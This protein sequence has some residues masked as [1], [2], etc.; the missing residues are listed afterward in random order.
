ML[1]NRAVAL[2]LTLLLSPAVL[3]LGLGALKTSSALNQR[4]DGRIDILGAT[5][6]DVDTL[7]ARLADTQQFD[8]AGIQ[9]DAI[10][11]DLKFE[12]VS[13]ESGKDYIRITSREPIREPFLNFLLELNWANGRVVR[14][15]TVLLDPPLYDANRR[16]AAPSRAPA[17][18]RP[19]AAPT[20]R[21]PPALATDPT[22]AAQ[23]A[24]RPSAYTPGG[25]IGVEANDTLWSLATQH[26]PDSSV[27]VHQMMIA[28]LRANPEAFVNGNINLLKRGAVLRVP[29]ADEVNQVSRSVALEEIRKQHQLWED[30]RH[31][32]S[33][34]ATAQ[35]LGPG[36]ESAPAPKAPAAATA[37]SDGRL[38]LAA[39]G[40]SEGKSTDGKAAAPGGTAGKGTGPEAAG[41]EDIDARARENV[42]LKNKLSEADKII[43]LLQRQVEIKDQELATLQAR[44][45]K[46]GLG[47]G[48]TAA[49]PET[50]AAPPATA[51]APAP[52]PAPPVAEK[53]AA[54]E[55]PKPA[56]PT[57]AATPTPEAPKPE[58]EKP[59]EPAQ[60]STPAEP[61]APAKPVAPPTPATPAAKPAP[62]PA[63]PGFAES[64]FPA[65][66]VH[67]VPGGA[68]TLLAVVG[69]VLALVV[70]A[71]VKKFGGRAGEKPM[72]APKRA[73]ATAAAGAAA[74]AALAEPDHTVEPITETR[75]PGR[76]VDEPPTTP[77]GT[78]ERTLEATADQLRAE[79][80]EDP[81]EEV[82]VYLAYERFD[83]A[84]ELVK[85]V[86]AQQPNEHKFKLRLL[87]I[88]YSANNKRAYEESARELLNAVGDK[89]PLWENAVAMWTE[90]SPDRPLFTGGGVDETPEAA[91]KTFVDITGD[92]LPGGET[93]TM[94][95]GR[96]H[97]LEST[98]VGLG[99]EASVPG[100]DFDLSETG[101]GP[102]L[103]MLDL[104]AADTGAAGGDIFDPTLGASEPGE[105]LDLTAG[106]ADTLDL[107]S[108]PTP[109]PAA[110]GDMF[111]ISGESLSAADL[112]ALEPPPVDLL[113]VTSTGNLRLEGADDLLSLT[114]PGLTEHTTPQPGH[115]QAEAFDLGPASR[116]AVDF[117]I[118][119]TVNPPPRPE[120]V[121]AAPEAD[122]DDVLDFDIEGLGFD[123]A[124]ADAEPAIGETSPL[125]TSGLDLSLEDD[126]G[127]LDISGGLGSDLDL[128]LDA[129]ESPDLDLTAEA[130]PDLD[131]S[132]QNPEIDDF[133]LEVDDPNAPSSNES[134]IEFDLALQD[135]TDFDS[136][137]VDDTL[138]LP[139]S[140]SAFGKLTMG[141]NVEES[142][143]D[144]TRSMEESMA[145]LDLEEDAKDPAFDLDMAPLDANAENALDFDIDDAHLET[146]GLDAEDID[147][148]ATQS[149]IDRTVVLPRDDAFDLQDDAD[150]VD[151]KLNLAK[152]YLELGDNE[153]ARSILDE[154]VRDGSD[155][156]RA[157]AQKLLEQAG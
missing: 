150:E 43:D 129:G 11:L 93:M 30:Y 95:P 75:A 62:K 139:K 124:P 127:V 84:E 143:E 130:G 115:S 47:A 103:D 79:P 119:D 26:R 107:D 87:E 66:L 152:A 82:N 37:P 3:A 114:A 86:I 111:D 109:E 106:A 13:P 14:E 24:S 140:S 71:L 27:T 68:M 42:E 38:E 88:Y 31:G 21:M 65:Q 48:D 126:D 6:E 134:D 97:V 77:T 132:L 101:A 145:A 19:A 137:R 4:F 67:A 35:P 32:A 122:I 59:V 156:Q 89:D 90:M 112:T 133:E 85:K 7:N 157:E 50:P 99:E 135:T 28:L 51:E 142:L 116:S 105:I 18:S 155:A 148:N 64:L 91:S 102:E 72:P 78:F 104:T 34:R 153:G 2:A 33:Q 123:A 118:S 16:A 25:S 10:L 9:R 36:A 146:L 73:A 149:H 53:P 63:A 58:A 128:E 8:R 69:G 56:E 147:F 110:S 12:I 39:P 61:V 96:D 81:L 76:G 60:P 100:L 117:D 120:L 55:A 98:Q 92:T 23:A 108:A 20:G 49:K 17:P 74:A 46:A 151:T 144:L 54:P 121:E 70:L 52:Q 45:A 83:Q 80:I 131:L 5:N 154:V 15:Y 22:T 40:A 29:S 113:D 44:M 41:K 138:E 141:E 57:A 94:Q 136:L 1:R 125:D